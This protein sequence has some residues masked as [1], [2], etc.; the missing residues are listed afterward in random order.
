MWGKRAWVEEPQGTPNVASR[1][2]CM[3][4]PPPAAALAKTFGPLANAV[5]GPRSDPTWSQCVLPSLL[6][7]SFKFEA[8]FY[9]HFF[10]FTRTLLSTR[11]SRMLAL[12]GEFMMATTHGTCERT[13][14]THSRAC[15]LRKRLQC[16]RAS[17]IKS[18]V[19]KDYVPQLCNGNNKCSR[20]V[21]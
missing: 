4:P 15:A 5:W 20:T 3:V 14:S 18:S 13:A 11:C 7:K 10:S 2:D 19:A 21:G 8:V 9:P 12:R 17:G 16:G 6:N 1:A